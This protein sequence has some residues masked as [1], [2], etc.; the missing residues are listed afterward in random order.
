MVSSNSDVTVIVPTLNEEE[1]IGPTLRELRGVLGDPFLLVVDGNST[2]K[3]VEVAKEFGAEAV[4][5]KGKGKGVALRQVFDYDGLNGD[6]I[7][8][9]DADGSMDP[10]EVP[11]FIKALESG[12]DVAKGSRFLLGGYSKDLSVARTV[13]NRILVS[14]VNFLFSTKYTD[15]CY[16]FMAFNRK[17]ISKLSSCLR[18]ENFEIET[19]ICIKA[20]K[21]GLKVAEVPSVELKRC[22]GRSHLRTFRDGFKIFKMILMEFF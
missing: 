1:G 3:T 11:L 8:M 16:G 20:K 9:M 5:Q 21:L 2:D 6:R 18:S 7:V 22:Y 17:A 12:A 15:M 19:E 14:L 4:L 13:G 10:K